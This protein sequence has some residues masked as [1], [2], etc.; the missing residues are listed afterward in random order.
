[1]S[2]PADTAPKGTYTVLV[3]H[4]ANRG[5]PD[6][7]EFRVAV[8]VDGKVKYYSGD[9]AENQAVHVCTFEK[10]TGSDT[11]TTSPQLDLTMPNQAA[12]PEGFV[13]REQLAAENLALAKGFIQ[14]TKY[15]AARK[16]LEH[17]ITEYPETQAANEARIL[18]KTLPQNDVTIASNGNPDAASSGYPNLPDQVFSKGSFT[19]WTVPSNPAP[20]QTY[21]IMVQI[22]I[23][24]SVSRY[25]RSDLSGFLVGTD[26]YKQHF[27]GSSQEGDQPIHNH[28][29]QLEATSVPG[30]K[31]LVKDVIHV[32][33]QILNEEQEIEI[34]FSGQNESAGDEGLAAVAGSPVLVPT[35]QV[36]PKTVQKFEY[37]LKTLSEQH[38]EFAKQIEKKNPSRASRWYGEIVKRYPKTEAA[39]IAKKW[40][41]IHT[42]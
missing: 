41:K 14:E 21:K 1:M 2:W 20:R 17:V 19:V 23:P 7:T 5:A 33:S 26:G 31:H 27:G 6:P 42:H 3:Y 24:E 8:K 16:W 4:Y 28:L 15:P 22:K 35:D 13:S 25:P 11:S 18:L 36:A 29:V 37:D 39:E 40:L 9:L 30:A 32:K 34:V 38:L 12:L 10:T